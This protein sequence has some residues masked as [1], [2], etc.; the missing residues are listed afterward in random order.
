MARAAGPPRAPRAW[1]LPGRPPAPGAA[2]CGAGSTS[3][4]SAGRSVPLRCSGSARRSGSRP[5]LPRRA[6]RG[7]PLL[8]V[9]RGPG[10]VHRGCWV[11]PSDPSEEH[12]LPRSVLAGGRSRSGSIP[13]GSITAATRSVSTRRQ[14][15]RRGASTMRDLP[16]VAW[17]AGRPARRGTRVEIARSAP[18]NERGTH[19]PRLGDGRGAPARGCDR[20]RPAGGG[21]APAPDRQRHLPRQPAG[22]RAPARAHPHA[23]GGSTG[24]SAAR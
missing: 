24:S 16:A 14:P 7:A 9:S 13:T 19:L 1:M 2:C 11:S 21:G 12:V 15:R 5:C 17:R 6:R 8:S 18:T 20:R 23:G 22:R 4:P 3:T 10:L